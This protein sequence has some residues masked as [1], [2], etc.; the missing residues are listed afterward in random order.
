MSLEQRVYVHV[1]YHYM[2]TN[3]HKFIKSVIGHHNFEKT[4]MNQIYLP[5]QIRK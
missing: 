5:N 3:K 1:N 4:D 2:I